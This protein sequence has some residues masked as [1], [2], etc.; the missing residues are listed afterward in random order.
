MA[1]IILCIGSAEDPHIQE[2][3]KNVKLLDNEARIVLF[4]P[5]CGGHF[6]E[7]TVDS[8]CELSSSCLIVVDGERIPAESI[9]SVWYRW[10][11]AV[12]SADED[13][14]GLIAKDFVLKEWRSVVRSL[15]AF[16]PHAQWL[17]T[18]AVTELLNSKPFQLQLAQKVGLTV[19]KTTITNNPEAVKEL[20]DKVENGR[21][22]FKSLTPLFL[23]PDKLLYT[24][25]IT[26]EFPSHSHNSI[27]Q[28][29]AIYQEL[30]E[31]RSDLRITV[32]GCEVFVARI[33]SQILEREKDRLD[34]RRCQDKEE[35]YSEVQ[36]SE[37]LKD[38]LLEFH[39]KAGLGF[40]AYD[41]LERG[42]DV[43]FLECNPGGAWL[44]LEQNLGLKVSEQVAKCLLGINETKSS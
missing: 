27:A 31:R 20:F 36:I 3:E 2:V 29:P 22:I 17:N 41:F 26:R 4:N 1:T 5:L 28:S 43:I 38:R 10:K 39:R 11:P 24:T 23:P 16:L 44:W 12:L 35:L 6:I 42:D 19:P 15:E 33:A 7:I 14:Q 34:W 32:V 25:E 8:S 30:V 40:G 21:V 9:K 18:V 37:E 13:L